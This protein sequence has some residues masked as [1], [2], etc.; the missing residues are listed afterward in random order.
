MDIN[1]CGLH[2]FDLCRDLRGGVGL[3]ELK[4]LCNNI[5]PKHNHNMLPTDTSRT[6]QHLEVILGKWQEED[7]AKERRVCSS[8]CFHESYHMSGELAHTCVNLPF[9]IIAFFFKNKL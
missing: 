5:K 1:P 2:V 9:V 8:Q 4:A 3:V 7:A 6:P